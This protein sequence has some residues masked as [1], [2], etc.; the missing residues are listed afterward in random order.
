MEAFL[1]AGEYGIALETLCWT[2][3]TENKLVSAE[4]VDGISKL[5][6]QMELD[7]GIWTDLAA[8]SGN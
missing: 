4:V 6:E 3:S 7:S 1:D 8:R 5:A 2:L